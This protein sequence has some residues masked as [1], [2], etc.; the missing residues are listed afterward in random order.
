MLLFVIWIKVTYTYVKEYDQYVSMCSCFFSCA[1]WPARASAACCCCC[2]RLRWSDESKGSSHCTHHL[3]SPATSLPPTR[4]CARTV[5]SS[6]LWMLDRTGR[7]FKWPGSL[8]AA[9]VDDRCCCWIVPGHHRC[10]LLAVARDKQ[11]IKF[12]SDITIIYPQPY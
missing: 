5:L 2:W 6:G 4:A 10:A 7:A 12:R 3:L 9:G 11:W 8:A 1:L